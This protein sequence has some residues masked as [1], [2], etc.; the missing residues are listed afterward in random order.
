[1]RLSDDEKNQIKRQVSDIFGEKSRVFLFGSRVDDTKKGGD[2]DLFI[3]AEIVTN[4]F[5]QTIRLITKLQMAL[6]D[7]KIDVVLAKDPSRLIEQEARQGGVL[8]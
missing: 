1:M 6:G 2:I 7:Q 8:L 3:E 4:G 5:E